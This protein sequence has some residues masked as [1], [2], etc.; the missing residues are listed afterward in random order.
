MRRDIAGD[1]SARRHHG[2]AADM[3]SG[4]DHAARSKA[5]AILDAGPDE[6][7]SPLFVACSDRGQLGSRTTRENIVGETDAGTDKNVISDLDPVPHHRLVLYGDAIA[8]A[9]SAFDEGMVAYVA[10]TADH[11]SLHHMRESPYLRA[12]PNVLALAERKAMN[13]GIGCGGHA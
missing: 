2:I 8:D 4:Q 7:P 10:V 6:P 3:S 9:S 1:D 13:K 12:G 11:C 5:R